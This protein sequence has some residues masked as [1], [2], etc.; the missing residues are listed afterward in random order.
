VREREVNKMGATGG[1]PWLADAGRGSAKILVV[2][3]RK[4]KLLAFQAIL[5]EL[6]QDIFTAGSGD[7]ALKL[8]LEHDFAVILLDVNMPGLDGLETAALIRQRKKSAHTPII[9]I[10]AYSDEMLTMQGY[11]L[12]AVDYILSPVV[13]DILRTKVRV[14]VDL[15]C[16]TES[17]KQQMEERIALAREQTA[18]AAAEEASRRSTLLSDASR[19]LTGALDVQARIQDL[20]SVV[21]PSLADLCSFTYLDE[22]DGIERTDL[23]WVMAGQPLRRTSPG[24]IPP[25]LAR[26]VERALATSKPQT[27]ENNRP[28]ASLNE[29]GLGH[30]S[31]ESVRLPPICSGAIF[32]LSARGRMV[33]VLGF[34]LCSAD[35]LFNK[36]D[37]L[38]LEDL[39]NRAAVAVDNA[40]LYQ[41]LQTADR[42]KN[43]F[44]AMLG[45]ELRNP[46]APIRNAVEL[47]RIAGSDTQRRSRAQDVIERQVKHLT[48]LVDDLLDVSRITRGKIE[49]QCSPLQ[50]SGV[51]SNAVEISMPLIESRKH[52]LSVSVP[53][54]PLWINADS[55]RLAQVLA[56]LLNNA[57]K[58]TPEGGSIS[59]SVG[60]EEHNIVFRVVDTGVGLS[61][62]MLS[63]IFDLFGRDEGPRSSFHDG[64][65]VGLMLVRRL[66][67]LHGG[68]VDAFSAGANKG[69]EFVVRVPVFLEDRATSA[70]PVTAKAQAAPPPRGVRV[71]VVDDNQDAAESTSMLLHAFGFEVQTVYDGAAALD[72]FSDFHPDA[73]LLDIGMPMMDGYEVARR[74]RAR[75]SGDGLA[76]IAVSGYGQDEDRRRSMEAGFDSHMTKPLDTPRLIEILN[77]LGCTHRNGKVS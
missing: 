57:A 47:L 39:A 67:E 38:L 23:A 40:L 35:R 7:E 32:P 66:V 41:Q 26:D 59:L 8:V 56:N 64:L 72:K 60:Q 53:P 20:F 43:D 18:R 44:L 6:E 55:G 22:H 49:L 51:I 21:V 12:G 46:L 34:A 42:H 75:P 9:F 45:H 10:T 71:L 1:R 37:W 16:L 61:R 48:R 5:Q 65:G 62:Q 50:V 77:S 13:P 33:G 17:A 3:D 54:Q 36:S 29:T 70:R 2:D 76:I 63:K 69:S 11:S 68:K 24:S 14:F 19:A 27:I 73:V 4:D 58:Y 52:R 31:D 74:L 25:A 28:S 30:D 15:F